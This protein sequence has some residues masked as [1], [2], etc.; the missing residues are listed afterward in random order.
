M[1]TNLVIDES[2][3]REALRLG[4]HSTRKQAVNEALKEYIQR[5][6]RLAVLKLFGTVEFDETYDYK[7]ERRMR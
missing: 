4:G 3:L 2:L 1:S 7:R 6:R 5:R